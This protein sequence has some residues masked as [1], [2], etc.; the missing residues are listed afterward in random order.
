[1]STW[2]HDCIVPSA[3]IDVKYTIK[4]PLVSARCMREV[5]TGAKEYAGNKSR[6]HRPI[7]PDELPFYLRGT[8]VSKWYYTEIEQHLGSVLTWEHI[9]ATYRGLM[10][11]V[12]LPRHYNDIYFEIWDLDLVGNTRQLLG[13]GEFGALWQSRK[14]VSEQ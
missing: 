1:M 3:N 2:L 13:T 11:C 6:E 7:Q 9:E 5:M 10:Y 14:V 12:Y 8:G 4:P